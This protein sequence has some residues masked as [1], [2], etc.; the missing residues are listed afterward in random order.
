MSVFTGNV[1]YN[2]GLYTVTFPAGMTSALFDIAIIDDNIHE[3]S[4]YFDLIIATVQDIPERIHFGEYLNATIFI[5][6]NDG[7]KQKVYHIA[8]K[9]G[10]AKVWRIYSFEHLAKKVW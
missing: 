10:R 8:G 6:D 4:E 9:F 1:D 3:E 7:I 2:S 5:E